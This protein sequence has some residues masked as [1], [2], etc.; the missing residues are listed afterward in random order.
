MRVNT[1]VELA[2]QKPELA[3]APVLVLHILNKSPFGK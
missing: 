1:Y 3:A 2:R